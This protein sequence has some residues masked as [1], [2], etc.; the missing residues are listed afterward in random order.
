M[1]TSAEINRKQFNRQALNFSNWSSTKNLEYLELL[2]KFIGLSKKDKLLDVACGSGDFVIYAS[3]AINYAT[4][5]D[6]SD[7]LVK[8]ANDQVR[9][10]GLK[11]IVFMHGN[12]E[13]L[14]FKDNSFSVVISKSA[15]HHFRNYKKVF[16]EM[17]RC[18]K[19]GGLI[20]IDDIT[21][22][23]KP[24][25]SNVIDYMDKLMDV[26]HN[27]RIPIG[28]FN[29]LFSKKGIKVIK[30]KV[31]EFERSV[32][33][34]QKHALQTPMNVKKVKKLIDKALSDNRMRKYLFKK[35]NKIYFMNRGYTILGTKNN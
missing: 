6:I 17:F 13:K 22:Y 19:P 11:N 35:E 23:D 15:F 16:D 31:N 33:D 2:L 12:V 28:E 14:P 27:H 32:D 29:K 9:K 1:K 4:G 21:T 20:C 5:I 10:L 8:I 34:Y 3:K 25:V 24:I 18:C 30:T 26:S 7:K